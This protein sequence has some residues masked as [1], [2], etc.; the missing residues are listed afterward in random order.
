M[1]LLT[2]FQVDDLFKWPKG[3][4]ERLARRGKIPY[5]LLPDGQ[6]VRFERESIE[7][8]I[9]RI[10]LRVSRRLNLVQKKAARPWAGNS[11]GEEKRPRHSRIPN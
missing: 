9:R 4:A 8:A 3:R 2:G 5:L 7:G 10:S 1:D 11:R 6:T